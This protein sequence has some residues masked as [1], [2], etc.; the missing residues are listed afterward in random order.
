MYFK[1]K[2]QVIKTFFYNFFSW[3]FLKKLNIKI[4]LFKKMI[5]SL[6]LHFGGHQKVF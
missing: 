2:C 4:F 1:D 5:D 3:Q 6:K